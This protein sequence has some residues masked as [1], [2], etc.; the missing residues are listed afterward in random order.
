METL[1]KRLTESWARYED[2]AGTPRGTRSLRGV[3]QEFDRVGI[4]E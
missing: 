2:S 3:G 4:L 1:V